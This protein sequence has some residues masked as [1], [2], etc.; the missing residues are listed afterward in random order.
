MP[1]GWLKVDSGL[2]SGNVDWFNFADA[3]NKT[4]FGLKICKHCS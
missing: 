3:I 1:C 4:G 2:Q